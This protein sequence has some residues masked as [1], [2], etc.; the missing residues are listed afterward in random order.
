MVILRVM[1]PFKNPAKGILSDMDTMVA[2][3]NLLTFFLE[4]LND[5]FKKYLLRFQKRKN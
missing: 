3:S 1:L 2:V 5:I 4:M